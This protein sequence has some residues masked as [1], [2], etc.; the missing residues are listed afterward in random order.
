MLCVH[1]S[2]LVLCVHPSVLV[3]CVF[4]LVCWYCV[5]TL[6]HLT[7]YRHFKAYCL[8]IRRGSRNLNDC[9]RSDCITFSCI[10]LNPVSSVDAWCNIP[11]NLFTCMSSRMGN[12]DHNCTKEPR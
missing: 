11:L 9:T 2:V 8:H 12:E 5:S 4:T 10:S 1:P 6:V 3:L 7:D